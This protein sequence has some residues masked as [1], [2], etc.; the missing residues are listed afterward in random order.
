M[1]TAS[2]GIRELQQHAS[3]L[4]LDVEQGRA[5]YHLTVQGRDTG[6]RLVRAAETRPERVVTAVALTSSPLW[7]RLMPEDARK[8]LLDA[9]EAGR[10]AMG[11]VG[12]GQASS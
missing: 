11:Y 3:K 12:D 6:V 9:V 7:R 1:V 2:V 5:E 10:E 4:V 8:Q